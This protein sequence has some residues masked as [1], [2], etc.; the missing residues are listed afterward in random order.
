[1]GGVERFMKE[2]YGD[3][4]DS[5]SDIRVLLYGEEQCGAG[6]SCG[7][8]IRDFWLIHCVISG[9]GKF[10]IDKKEYELSE[11]QLFFIPPGVITYYQAD[12]AEPWHYAWVGLSGVVVR[13][14]MESAGLSEKNPVMSCSSE[15]IE[16]VRNIVRESDAIGTR[17]P[18]IKG[19]AYFFIDELLKCGAGREKYKSNGNAYVDHALRMI[20]NTIYGKISISEIAREVGIDRSYLCNIFKGVVGCSPQQYIITM[21]MN[22]AKNFLANTSYDIKYIATSLGYDDQFVF[23]HAFRTKAGISPSEWRA[24]HIVLSDAE[25]AE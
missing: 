17:S 8:H 1:M 25:G 20:H 7:P 10:V 6:H 14:Y 5:Y 13:S 4:T 2:I 21:K 18:R 11:N 15:L 9:R 3:N 23:S 24:K 22:I 16:S 19:L 12:M